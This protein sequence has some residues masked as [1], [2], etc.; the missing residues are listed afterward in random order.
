[1]KKSKFAF[2][3][4]TFLIVSSCFPV[5][6]EIPISSNDT[7]I[8]NDDSSVISNDEQDNT[9]SDNESNNVENVN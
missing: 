2:V 6:A 9:I 4:G 7:E 8:V 3:L 1:M 5:K